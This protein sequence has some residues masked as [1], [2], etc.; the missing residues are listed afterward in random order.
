MRII[1]IIGILALVSCQKTNQEKAEDLIST[2]KD[3]DIEIKEIECGVLEKA[4]LNYELTMPAYKL[5][6][7]MRKN[8][9]IAKEKQKFIDQWKDINPAFVADDIEEVQKRAKYVVELNDSFELEKKRFRPDTTRYMMS[10]K[11]HHIN[12]KTNKMEMVYVD[13]FFDKDISRIVGALGPLN[14]DSEKAVYVDFER[15]LNT[16]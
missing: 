1:Y 15:D 14:D 8:I 2:F 7:E 13:F 4:Q 10:V 6:E 16:P 9:E 5:R 11:L 3:S 12:P